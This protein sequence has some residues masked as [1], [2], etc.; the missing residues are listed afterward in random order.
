MAENN[1]PIPRWC[2]EC[3]HHF[4]K[5]GQSS[6]CGLRK[7][8]MKPD[9]HAEGVDHSGIIGRD[10]A[11]IQGW[12]GKR[13]LDVVGE[14][15]ERYAR[16]AELVAMTKP[17]KKR[18]TKKQPGIP[19][20]KDTTP[21]PV[22]KGCPPAAHG[23]EECNTIPAR[24][25]VD[26]QGCVKDS[27]M[28]KACVSS[29]GCGLQYPTCNRFNSKCSFCTNTSTCTKK[30][31]PADYSC[32][33]GYVTS[34]DPVRCT[35]AIDASRMDGSGKMQPFDSCRVSGRDCLGTCKDDTRKGVGEFC[36]V[37]KGCRTGE[38]VAA[39]HQKHKKKDG[40]E[41]VGMKEPVTVA[42]FQATTGL[43]A[44]PAPKKPVARMRLF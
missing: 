10:C 40:Q 29:P 4:P 27:A 23:I 5:D 24:G 44:K 22:V 26:A 7:C 35:H 28:C 32:Y 16:A 1:K 3:S 2:A 43:D 34:P 11:G 30:D 12:R 18:V 36:V 9:F 6:L 37:E 41:R 8:T 39:Y 21:E 38:D 42:Q 15:R 14:V 31:V 20:I 17:K 19:V 25:G 33:K 13:V